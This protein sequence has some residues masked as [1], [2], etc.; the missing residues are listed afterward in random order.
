METTSWEGQG[1]VFVGADVQGAHNNKKYQDREI[2]IWFWH[3]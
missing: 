1:S 2:L 3:G